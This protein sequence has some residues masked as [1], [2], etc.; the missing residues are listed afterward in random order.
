MFTNSAYV[1][2]YILATDGGDVLAL[3]AGGVGDGGA[4]GLDSLADGTQ[5]NAGGGRCGGR[6]GGW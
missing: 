6:G 2:I 4:D 1:Y 5:T 3:G